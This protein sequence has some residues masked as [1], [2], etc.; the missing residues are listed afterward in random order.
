MFD[1]P[2]NYLEYI[3]NQI[4]KTYFWQT[5]QLAP[6][7]FYIMCHNPYNQKNIEKIN[8]KRLFCTGISRTI[9]WKSM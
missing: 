6:I 7:E 3:N 9:S 8:E 1:V 4:E 2:V 5:I